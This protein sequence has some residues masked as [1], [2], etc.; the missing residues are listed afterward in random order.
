MTQLCR[1]MPKQF[2][3]YA[4]FYS[5]ADI[6]SKLDYGNN[7][8]NNVIT[9]APCIFKD[10][11]ELLR[12]KRPHPLYYKKLYN[13]IEDEWNCRMTR[14]SYFLSVVDVYDLEEDLAV[15]MGFLN[16]ALEHT[17]VALLYVFWEFKPTYYK[18]DYLMYMCGHFTNLPKE[19]F[20]RKTYKSHR[21]YNTLCNA[22]HLMRYSSNNK[23][24]YEI[25]DT[26]YKLCERFFQEAEV[27]GEKHLEKLKK[28][29]CK[30]TIA[31]T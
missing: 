10:D 28:L 18:L 4:I 22:Y 3:A 1:K 16:F 9:K 25:L 27:I 6:I 26:A 21:L 14:A 19:I 15:K 13:N 8:L 11:D 5:L 7:F 29:H 2:K 30:N 24:S 12:Y 31:K 17:C 23:V 20:H